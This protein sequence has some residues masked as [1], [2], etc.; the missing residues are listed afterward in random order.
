MGVSLLSILARICHTLNL[1]FGIA[2]GKNRSVALT[3]LSNVAVGYRKA[4]A[5]NEKPAVVY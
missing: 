4:V 1:A 2:C 5:D 3:V